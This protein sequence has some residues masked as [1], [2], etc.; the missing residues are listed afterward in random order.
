L[1]DVLFVIDTNKEAIAVAEANKLG[2]P[3]V[4]VID[5][6]SDPEGIDFAVPGNDDSIRAINLYCDLI[7]G[8][9]LAGIQAEIGAAGGDLGEAEEVPEEELPAEEGTPEA[10]A[11][12]EGAGEA[13]AE[14]AEPAA[15]EPAPESPAPESEEPAQA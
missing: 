13:A 4:G 3:V 6:N 1:P 12:A 11:A 5:S 8:S 7:S 14:T 9:V 15:E 10:P 2:I